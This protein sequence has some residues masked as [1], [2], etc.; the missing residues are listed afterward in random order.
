MNT[1]TDTITTNY[2]FT[3]SNLD[4]MLLP[5]HNKE[6]TKMMELSRIIL[7]IVLITAAKME[8]EPCANSMWTQSVIMTGTL[9]KWNTLRAAQGSHYK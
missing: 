2:K 9:V 1:T 7:F 3:H 6:I 8:I 5:P 4:S